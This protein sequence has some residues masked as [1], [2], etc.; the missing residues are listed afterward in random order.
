M[1]YRHT[2][3]LASALAWPIPAAMAQDA[4]ATSAGEVQGASPGEI[5][6]TA[7][8]RSESLQKA[9]VAITALGGEA[10]RDAARNSVADAISAVP[11]VQIQ[12]N[13]NGAQIYIRGVGSNADSQLGDPAVNL[14]IDGIYQQQTEVPTALM[15]DVKRIEV[16]RG[17]QGTL[18]G[19][20]ATAGAVNIVTTDP[21]L[22]VLGG[23][24]MVQA[25]NY[26]AVHGEGAINVPIGQDTALRVAGATDH[27][28]GYLSNGN[29]NA[30]MSAARVKLLSEPTDNLRILI[31]A[32]YL[33]SAGHDVGSVAAPL[34]KSDPW[35]SDK[36]QGYINLDSLMVRGQVDYTTPFATF[37][38]LA[39][40]T[41]YDKDEANVILSPTAVSVHREARQNSVELRASSPGHSPIEWVGGLFYYDDTEVRQVVDSPIDATAASASNPEL[42]DATAKSAAAFANVTVPL[43]EALRLT[44]GLRYTHDEKGARFVYTDGSGDPD[45]TASRSWNSFTYKAGIEADLAPQSLLYGQV[46]SGFKAGG[47]A[48]QFPAASYDPEKITA[49]E[50]GSKN[51]LLDNT[52]TLNLAAFHYS[53]RDYQA[54]YP[55]LVDG[56]FALV[57]ANAASAKLS[58]AELEA[59]W[60]PTGSD[61]LG[62]S[63]SYLHTRFGA[64]SYTSTLS[65][66]VDH[67]NERLPNSP[68]ASFDVSYEHV[69]TLGSGATITAHANSHISTGYWTTVERSTDSYQGAF[70]RSDAFLRYAPASDAWDLRLYAKNIENNAIRTLGAANPVDTVLL[71]APPR[72]YGAAFSLRF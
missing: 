1:A 25:G 41:A 22:G 36:P 26:K 30:H 48:Q 66:T 61:T 11:S 17:P 54:Q 24:G 64:F 46:S 63:A 44:G 12:G 7:Q 55:D 68:T 56:A 8:R 42:R 28:D 20:N 2:L 13:T 51:R 60:R 62:L 33:H 52:L 18:Y 67:S 3:L 40:H 6:V 10:L 31:G 4:P 35:Y 47:F 19:R 50:I 15:Y 71:L 65:G 5:I 72:T 59:T 49:F 16:L 39:S 43:T 27:H 32:D 57:T 38:L 69:F 21:E 70:T 9:A 45:A 34:D 53:Y 29:N 14:N 58:G 23:Y 37:T